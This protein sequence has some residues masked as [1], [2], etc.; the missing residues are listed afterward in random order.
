ME[1]IPVR[2]FIF[3]NVE[4]CP[5]K[6]VEEIEGYG[7]FYVVSFPADFKLE[8]AVI[9][10]SDGMQFTCYDWQGEQPSSAAEIGEFRWVDAL[11]NEAIMLDGLPRTLCID[12]GIAAKLV[13]IDKA[14][15]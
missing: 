4:K 7:M 2:D 9:V 3:G 8:I 12:A 14:T 1:T 11:G 10:A 5:V 6:H 15:R 13:E